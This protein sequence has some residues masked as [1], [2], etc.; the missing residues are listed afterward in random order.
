MAAPPSSCSIEGKARA[1]RAR[2][3]AYLGTQPAC[4]CAFEQYLA[5]YC[6]NAFY[7]VQKLDRHCPEADAISHEDSLEPC[8][9]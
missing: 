1:M 2:R 5:Q 9:G 4:A 8:K 6:T 7:I 3:L